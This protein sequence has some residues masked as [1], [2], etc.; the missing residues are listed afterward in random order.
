M[1]NK[2]MKEFPLVHQYEGSF[3]LGMDADT[4]NTTY[5][6][7]FYSDEGLT[8]PEDVHVSPQ[9][10]TMATSTGGGT[11][12]GSVINKIRVRIMLS[13]P[14]TADSYRTRE[15]NQAT[16]ETSAGTFTAVS[17]SLASSGVFDKLVYKTMLVHGAFEDFDTVDEQSGVTVA[18]SL[19]LVSATTY[20][21]PAYDNTAVFNST[22]TMTHAELTAT[23]ILENIIFN[24]DTFEDVIQESGV[25][26]LVKKLTSGGLRTHV[27]L[28]QFASY[29]MNWFNVPSNVKRQNRNTFCGLMFHL[30]GAGGH[31]QFYLPAETTNVEHLRVQY[32]VR[33]NEYNDMFSQSN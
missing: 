24:E 8:N 33:F 26:G 17:A 31:E 18:S 15:G 14:P 4:Q 20:T 23:G 16:L 1:P 25:A 27:L 13:I 6:P 3:G 10:A 11:Y 12:F 32:D 2:L 5:I 22:G 30:P 7:L 28:K 29:R 21:H 9:S 19:G